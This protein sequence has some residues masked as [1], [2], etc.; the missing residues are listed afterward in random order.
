MSTTKL[1]GRE[2]L[3]EYAFCLAPGRHTDKESQEDIKSTGPFKV[4]YLFKTVRFGIR[5]RY[6]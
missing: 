6:R 2:N 3:T 5:I 4:H 1:T